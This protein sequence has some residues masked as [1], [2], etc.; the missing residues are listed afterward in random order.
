MGVAAAA[1]GGVGLLTAASDYQQQRNQLE[2]TKYQNSV[3]RNS[4]LEQY[5]QLRQPEVD[6]VKRGTQQSLSNQLNM[7]Q[8]IERAKLMASA[9]GTGGNSV[10][11]LLSDLRAQGGR[12]QSA[13]INNTERELDGITRQADQIRA[14][15][16]SQLRYLKKPS[17]VQSLISGASSAAS[18]YSIA[19]GL[20][21]GSPASGSFAVSASNSAAGSGG[22]K[23]G[24]YF[25]SAGPTG[26]NYSIFGG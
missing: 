25:G 6:I 4:V 26:V 18:A 9:S 8:L 17:A 19:S 2:L 14:T 1:A 3:V 12:N 16:I 21:W 20:G 10:N 23:A 11:T 24:S 22:L 5:S 15:G 7:I 13:I